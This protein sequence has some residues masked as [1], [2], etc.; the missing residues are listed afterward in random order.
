MHGGGE[1]PRKS[2]NE[3]AVSE[4]RPAVLP[5]SGYSHKNCLSQL[6]KGLILLHTTEDKISSCSVPAL[7]LMEQRNRFR[8]GW[9]LS[10]VHFQHDVICCRADKKMMGM[11][12]SLPYK[13]QLTLEWLLQVSEVVLPSPSDSQVAPTSPGVAGRG[14]CRPGQWMHPAARWVGWKALTCECYRLRLQHQEQLR[15]RMCTLQGEIFPEGCSGNSILE[16]GC[17]AEVEIQRISMV[18]EKAVKAR[19]VTAI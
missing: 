9:K 10:R 13:R 7:M 8:E 16:R 3:K 11:G 5:S 6:K 4:D 18:P 1:L 19:T 15:K 12:R 2:K 17:F 14:A